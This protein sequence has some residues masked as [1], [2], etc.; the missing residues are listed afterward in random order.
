M[1]DTEGTVGATVVLEP[2]ARI[3]DL[4]LERE[5]G[6][7]AQGIVFLARQESMDRTVAVKVLPKEITYTSEQ[8]ERFRREAEA[9]GRLNHPNIVSVYEMLEAGGHN[10][11]SQEFVPGG[12]LED[13]ITE[14]REQGVRTNAAHCAWA[15]GVCRQLADALSHAHEHHV[16]HR[17]MKPANVLLTENGLP[18][19]TDFGLAKVEDKMDLS[20]T[21]ALMGTPNYMSPEQVSARKDV[22]GRTDVYS[23]GAMLYEML[24]FQLPFTAES[25]QGIFVDI[26]SRAPKPPRSLQPGIS[27]DLE[28]VCLRCLE[29]DPDDRY[30]DAGDLADDLQRFLD[31]EATHARPLSVVGQTARWVRRQSAAALAG[32]CLLVPTAAF[33]GDLLLHKAAAEDL[34]LHDVRLGVIAG[35]AL[36][37]L[38]PAMMLGTRL[39]RGQTFGRWPAA[40]LVLA[41]AVWCG[42]IVRDQRTTQI[43]HG[44]RA[45]LAAS[46]AV[47]QAGD[48]I[49]G[50]DLRTYADTWA[51]RLDAD[52]ARLLARGWLL[53]AHPVLAAE[54]L[55]RLPGDDPLDAALAASVHWALGQEGPANE[56]ESRLREHASRSADASTWTAVGHTMRDM[57]RFE[58]A[59]DAYVRAGL[60]EGADRDRLNLEL[61]RVCGELCETEQQ[62]EYLEDYIKWR[63]DDPNAQ[64]MKVDIAQQLGDWD[65]A[66]EGNAELERIGLT[67]MAIEQEFNT[68][69]V[70]DRRVE[71]FETLAGLAAAD[72]TDARLLMSVVWRA[73]RE[74]SRMEADAGKAQAAGDTDAAGRKY[75]ES[76]RWLTLAYDTVRD[77]LA[78]D[79]TLHEAHSMLATVALRLLIYQPNRADEHLATALTAA[80]R[81][82]ELDPTH[83]QGHYDVAVAL[84]RRAYHDHGTDESALDLATI[85][86]IVT[87][88]RE[89]VAMHG[90]QVRPLNDAAHFLGLIHDRTGE[91]DLLLE[92]LGYARRATRQAALPDGSSCEMERSEASW[93]SSAYTTLRELQ[94]RDGDLRGALASAEQA[95]AVL[96]P[97]DP[98]TAYREAAVARLR[99]ELGEG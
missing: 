28:A 67:H 64:R 41:L 33:A 32:A 55:A 49:D 96:P 48:R 93:L 74:S 46:L 58:E 16:L 70:Q 26:L 99:D 50:D 15:A 79:D 98:R 57:R 9:A 51:E 78:D 29:K 97:G 43:H 87:P 4:V 45:A 86:G 44:D 90:L 37:A 73:L 22:D 61:A 59:R 92:A 35:A 11:I 36:L 63:P 27:P 68:L 69:I 84:A 18:K 34:G 65:A 12:D 14:H 66:A 94:E 20:R 85:E 71:A 23:L 80:R 82:V 89:A 53:R 75:G 31:G 21:G 39:A 60:S 17:D 52:D 13:V 5:V 54:W 40:A 47:E 30:R 95:L 25:M 72:D 81:T 76:L 91:G 1:T 62:L 77:L 56:A 6:R 19:I 42:F 3:H 7:G 38:Y 2:G 88:L 83:W 8:V 10:M 24:T